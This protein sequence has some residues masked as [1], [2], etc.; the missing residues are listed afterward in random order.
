L[1]IRKIVHAPEC[2]DAIDGKAHSG[3]RAASRN[4]I[5][6]PN[7]RVWADRTAKTPIKVLAFGRVPL[8]NCR[9]NKP[10]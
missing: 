8:V 6:M 5:A 10:A 1:A 4:A 2:V 9:A 3:G 7:W